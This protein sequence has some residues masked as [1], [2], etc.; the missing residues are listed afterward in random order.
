MEQNTATLND[1]NI[2][3]G[4]DSLG[5]CAEKFPLEAVG[6]QA[7]LIFTHGFGQNR[8]SW[9]NSARTLSANGFDC[10]CLDAR[11][12]GDSEWSTS[13]AYELD[14]FVWDL[15]KLA[16]HCQ[17]QSGL[18]PILIGASMGGLVGMLAECEVPAS[19]S[20]IVL[21]D[22][23]PRWENAGVSRIFEFMRAHPDGFEDIAAAAAAVRAY[24]PHRE[25]QEPERLRGHLRSGADGRLRWHWDPC[26]L[27]YIPKAAERY[28]A[29]LEAAASRVKCPLLLLS[30]GKSDVVSE[31]TIKHFL[32][33]VPH[34]TH[35]QIPDA[36][37]MIVGDRNDAFCQSIH[38]YL[39]LLS[40]PSLL[41]SS[42]AQPRITP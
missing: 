17:Q 40:Q 11:G 19:F 18:Q 5:L 26:L 1:S 22:V 20:A 23:T 32:D 29:R 37:H 7:T 9:R 34:A 21:V 2:F 25:N 28:Q 35:Q 3:Y 39:T 12:H 4:H 38:A 33:L 27:Q 15:S 24:L 42:Q 13:G 6:T 16:Q 31:R 10:I 8:L 36:T 41:S 30:G 14:D